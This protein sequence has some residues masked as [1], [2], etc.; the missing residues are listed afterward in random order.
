M[1]NNDEDLF[2]FL[3]DMC[4]RSIMAITIILLYFFTKQILA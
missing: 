3:T 2:E 1:V 4:A